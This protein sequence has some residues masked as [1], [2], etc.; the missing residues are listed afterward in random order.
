MKKH[1]IDKVPISACSISSSSDSEDLRSSQKKLKVNK[2]AN[3]KAK[4]AWKKLVKLQLSSKSLSKEAEKKKRKDA[5]KSLDL[6]MLSIL[7]QHH[8][9][10]LSP[11]EKIKLI[12]EIYKGQRGRKP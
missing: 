5:D 12:E 10:H 6:K 7:K 4:K 8:N 11:K 1:H 9:V 3:K 2:K